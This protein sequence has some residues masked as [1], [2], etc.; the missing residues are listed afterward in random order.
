[1]EYESTYVF[2]RFDDLPTVL[3]TPQG[4]LWGFYDRNNEKDQVG[5]I[6]L[7]TPSVVKE[8]SKEIRTGRHVQ[9]DWPL[10]NQQFPGYD[11][12]PFEHKV[13]DHK[14][15]GICGFDDEVWM[16]TQSGSQWDGLKHD[17]YGEAAV[18]YNGLKYEDAL[19]SH[20]NGTH[21][22]AK[23]RDCA[24]QTG[25]KGVELL[26]VEFSLTWYVRF[27]EKRDGRAP[28][29]WTRH[30]I[31]VADL[32]AALQDQAGTQTRQGDILMIRSGYVKRHNEATPAEREARTSGIGKPAMGVA[33]DE[34][35]VHWMYDR[36]FAA[37][38]GDTVA[39]EAWPP[40]T[41]R[42][43]S[44][45]NWSLVWWGTPLGE[46]WD[47]EK[48]AQECE[49]QGRWSFFCTSAPLH[50]RGGVASPP[51]AIAIF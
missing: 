49:R 4:C 36:H 8:S 6:N 44:F 15:L 48:L 21:R 18:F 35:M 2:P 31:K 46:L 42:K 3:D 17:G 27:Y 40:A 30:E 51:C 12:K 24:R 50:V 26:D 43:Y 10:N 20:T 9:L 39:F 14:P 19:H 25:A 34:E 37:H 5:A 29:P 23:S 32:E 13:I 45:H 41:N 33:A 16:N 11:R 47:L 38:V 28:D 1:M 7:L 22:K